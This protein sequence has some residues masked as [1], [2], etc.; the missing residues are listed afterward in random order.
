M[1]TVSR[2]QNINLSKAQLD[3]L[4]NNPAGPVGRS[5]A[6]RGRKVLAA[7]RFTTRGVDHTSSLLLVHK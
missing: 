1:A 3:Y 2:I 4:L 5:L 6:R 7:A